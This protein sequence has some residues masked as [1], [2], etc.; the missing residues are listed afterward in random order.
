MNGRR[1]FAC[2]PPV[3]PA[4]PPRVAFLGAITAAGFEAQL[5]P[6]G[7]SDG[8]EHPRDSTRARFPSGRGNQRRGWGCGPF[9]SAALPLQPLAQRSARR[10]VGLNG[11]SRLEPVRTHGKER[12]E[13]HGSS[14]SRRG[15]S[16]LVSS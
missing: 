1:D 16:E 9:R 8:K 7:G 10:P 12:A 5:P 2:S 13:R 14:R 11:P 3:A 15:V 4:R 6:D